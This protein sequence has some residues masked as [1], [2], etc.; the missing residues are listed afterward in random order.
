MIL[1]KPESL[2]EMVNIT[3]CYDALYWERQTEQ[4]LTC[5]FDPKPTLS[6]PSE[7]LCTPTNTLPPTNCNSVST[8]RQ[9]E[10]P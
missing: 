6:H 9:P 3:V 5:R 8:L 7:P 4:R 1:G 10:V 2:R